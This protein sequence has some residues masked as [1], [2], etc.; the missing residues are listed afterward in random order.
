M[1]KDNWIWERFGTVHKLHNTVRMDRAGENI[2][3]GSRIDMEL[4]LNPEKSFS[5]FDSSNLHQFQPGRRQLQ[6]FQP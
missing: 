3:L 6:L 4:H 5:S 2:I 1:T